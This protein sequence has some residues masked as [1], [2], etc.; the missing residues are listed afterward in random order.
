MTKI[1]IDMFIGIWAFV[2]AI[3]WVLHIEPRSGDK[4]RKSEIWYRFPK[5]VV[6]YFVAW[7]LVMGIG[8]AGLLP[9]EALESGFS[10]VEGSLRKFFFMLTFTSIGIVTDFRELAKEGLG[11]LTLAYGSILVFIIIPIGF[12]LAW[13]FHHGMMP[14]SV[15]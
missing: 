4:V 15:S 13:L 6:G 5:F 7:F 8:L 14:P 12:F 9:F 10:P 1:W 2:L 11:K 3:I